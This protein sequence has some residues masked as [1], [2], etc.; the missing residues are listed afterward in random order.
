MSQQAVKKKGGIK[1]SDRPLPC[2]GSIA[3]SEMNCPALEML[4]AT[5]GCGN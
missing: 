2:Q 5:I 1:S 4:D 3:E